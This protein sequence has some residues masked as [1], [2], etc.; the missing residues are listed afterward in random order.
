ASA[1]PTFATNADTVFLLYSGSLDPNNPSDPLWKEV[2]Q[3]TK[4]KQF[5][6]VSQTPAGVVG[7]REFRGLLET[8]VKNELGLTNGMISTT[9][10]DKIDARIQ[11][12]LYG[13]QNGARLSY[14]KLDDI[15]SYAED[16]LCCQ[17]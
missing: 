5:V 14:K 13:E 1:Q 8:A 16:E 12:L 9:D 10:L 17:M 6:Q 11:E 3:L 2:N 4:D 15:L 7:S